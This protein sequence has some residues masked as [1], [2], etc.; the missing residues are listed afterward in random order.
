MECL[1]I[2]ENAQAAASFTEGSNSSKQVLKASKA[3]EETT[4]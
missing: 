2:Y 3:P 1:A 4:A